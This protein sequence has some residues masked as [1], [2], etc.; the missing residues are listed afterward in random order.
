[1]FD[2]GL[3]WLG[4]SRERGTRGEGKENDRG[5]HSKYQ[6]K[7]PK[8]PEKQT[9]HIS[10]ATPTSKHVV[11]PHNYTTN[12]AVLKSSRERVLGILLGGGNRGYRLWL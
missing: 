5:R 8:K 6:N 10:H 12:S 7:I 4:A 1:M 11:A 3:D 2:F 9:H